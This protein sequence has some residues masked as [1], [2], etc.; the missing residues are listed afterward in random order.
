MLSDAKSGFLWFQ[1]FFAVQKRVN[2]LDL[3][4]SF[5]TIAI[6]TSMYYSLAKFGIDT[7]ENEPCK[8]IGNLIDLVKSFL[9]S[10]WLRHLVSIRR[11]DR[12]GI[13]HHH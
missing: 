11:E 10:V 7:A 8:V 5:Q 12:S 13:H 2:L 6:Q 9:T 1:S 4:K 3:V